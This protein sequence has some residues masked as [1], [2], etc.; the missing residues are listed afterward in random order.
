MKMADITAGMVKTLRERTGAA[1][2]DCKR[3]LEATAGDID[4]AAEKMRMDG[5]AKADKKAARIAAEG[6]IAVAG[7]AGAAVLVEVNCETD[8]VAKGD[9]FTAF[10]ATAARL[11]LAHQPVDVDA[12]SALEDGGETL[13]VR[14]RNMVAKLGE[15]ISLRRFERVDAAGGGLAW[16]LHGGRIGAVV[17]LS[18]GTAE[19]AKDLAMHVAASK[20]QYVNAGAV[21]AEVVEAERRIIEGQIAEQAVGKPPEIVS[22]MVEGKLRKFLSE[23]TLTGQPFIKDPDQT[24]EKLLKGKSAAVSRFVRFEVGEGIEKK[25]GDFAAE[26]MA[27]AKASM[28]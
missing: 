15:N 6:T 10:A 18:S 20:P 9:E 8:F 3:A 14:R 24:V 5:Q 28:G 2:M 27:Q 13:D 4:A 21:P 19:L 11:A 7:N 12:L 22:K 17:S 23:I 26:V 1:M 16:Y 25:Q